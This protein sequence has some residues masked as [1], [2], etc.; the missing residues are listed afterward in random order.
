MSSAADVLKNLDRR[1][2]ALESDRLGDSAASLT[3]ILKLYA[4]VEVEVTTRYWLHRYR[5][6]GDTQPLY[7]AVCGTGTYL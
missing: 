5:K 1:V 2:G 7:G 3:Q 6:C 4:D